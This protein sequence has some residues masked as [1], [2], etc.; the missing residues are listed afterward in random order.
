MRLVDHRPVPPAD[1]VS[2]AGGPVGA[3]GGVRRIRG[4]GPPYG[5]RPRR[6][7]AS[8]PV[9]LPRRATV[10]HGR[11]IVLTPAGSQVGSFGSGGCASIHRC[12][13]AEMGRFTIVTGV[14]GT[15]E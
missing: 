14:S 8:G 12:S 10:Q 6:G 7:R 4:P 1:P 15:C 13:D 9:L 5:V 3:A 11:R 2:P